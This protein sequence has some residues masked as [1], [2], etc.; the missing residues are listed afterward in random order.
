MRFSC[1]GALSVGSGGRQIGVKMQSFGLHAT[2]GKATGCGSKLGSLAGVGPTIWNCTRA[3]RPSGS[4]GSRRRLSGPRPLVWSRRFSN[5]MFSVPVGLPNSCQM[6]LK[7]MI[8]S[9]RSATPRRSPVGDR[10]YDPGNSTG[11]GRKLPSVVVTAHSGIL[12]DG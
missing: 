8:T 5:Q 1:A 12:T 2:F 7:S 9:Q 4:P 3:F 11:L 6:R 10:E